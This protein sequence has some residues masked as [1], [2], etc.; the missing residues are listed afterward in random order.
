MLRLDN[1]SKAIQG[2]PVIRDFTLVLNKGD[3]VC[4]T[5][6]SGIG[7]T[8]LVRIAAGLTAPD[9]GTREIHTRK[10]GYAFQ[11]TPLIPW[12]T[13]MQNLEFVCS[14]RKGAGRHGD[15]LAQARAW[16][17]TMGLADA[18][19]KKPGELSGGM[20]RRLSIACGFAVEPELFFLDEPFAFLDKKWQ[21]TVAD[22]LIRENRRRRMTVFMVSHQPEPVRHM[23][24]RVVPL[25]GAD[26]SSGVKS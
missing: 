25:K 9:R 1:I 23:G 10:I 13:V 26:D 2:R 18:I 24:A 15:R 20:Q 4:V 7:K 11:D 8:T 14:G 21:E 6:P 19:H 12:R 5:G 17:E 3:M 16:I 22:E